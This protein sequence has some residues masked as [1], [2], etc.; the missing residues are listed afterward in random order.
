MERQ[1]IHGSVLP[2]HYPPR[3]P[4]PLQPPISQNGQY[5]Y[6]NLAYG[7]LS[8]QP[9]RNFCYYDDG[10]SGNTRDNCYNGDY[11]YTNSTAV[12][13]V[14]KKNG[15]LQENNITNGWNELMQPTPLQSTLLKPTSSQFY[16]LQCVPADSKPTPF[17][18][19]QFT[20]KPTDVNTK[21]NMTLGVHSPSNNFPLSYP[22]HVSDFVSE[23]GLPMQKQ[24][25]SEALCNPAKPN[26]A[27]VQTKQHEPMPNQLKRSMTAVSV[28]AK[29]NTSSTSKFSAH[30][31]QVP[32]PSKRQRQTAKDRQPQD[33]SDRVDLVRKTTSTIQVPIP[34]LP[35]PSP[36]I[37]A[38][39]APVKPSTQSSQLPIIKETKGNIVP[40]KV[41]NYEDTPRTGL[42]ELQRYLK[43]LE[44][45]ETE[46]KIAQR[47]KEREEAENQRAKAFEWPG[48]PSEYPAECFA[49]IRLP[50]CEFRAHAICIGAPRPGLPLNKY[51]VYPKR[52]MVVYAVR[53]GSDGVEFKIV[54]PHSTPEQ[55]MQAS[56][57]PFRDIK[58]NTDFSDMDEARVIRWSRY[59]LNA[60]PGQN[61]SVTMWSNA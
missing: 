26:Q 54:E 10:N 53:Q 55:V 22:T 51:N 47:E 6:D 12:S 18:M 45:R 2:R 34:R 56:R 43:V 17:T 5:M 38:P 7:G 9:A 23:R 31:A 14:S 21:P 36:V 25:N 40:S 29:D 48:D 35:I 58:L 13:A 37:K 41:L 30:E 39:L 59:L 61:D 33:N 4:A 57:I 44:Q 32:N 27:V 24:W 3:Q 42:E 15:L 49:S 16:P 19:A 1:S 60:V 20:A 11:N 46:A 50:G 28:N 8:E 52:R